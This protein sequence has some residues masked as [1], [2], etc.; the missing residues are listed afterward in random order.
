MGLTYPSGDARSNTTPG[1]PATRPCLDKSPA[2][3]ENPG[4]LPRKGPDRD[5]V[6]ARYR[7]MLRVLL[8]LL[9]TSLLTACGV[10]FGLSSEEEANLARYQRNAATYYGGGEFGRALDQARRG[11]EIDPEDYKLHLIKAWCALRQSQFDERRLEE[12]TKAFD[13]VLSL[14]SSGDQDPQAR[15]GYGA[16]HGKL[17]F[18][19]RRQ[20]DRLRTEAERLQLEGADLEERLAQATELDKESVRHFDLAEIELERLLD[21]GDLQLEAHYHLMYVSVWRDRHEEAVAHGSRYVERVGTLQAGIR[22]K[23]EETMLVDYERD[24]RIRLQKRLDQEVE[25]RAFLANLHF[26]DGHYELVVEQLDAVLLENP[27]RFNEF[28]NRARALHLLGRNEEAKRDFERFLI[29]T[30]LP[31]ENPQVKSA[32]AALK[33][34]E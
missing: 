2:L 21:S 12:A 23:L 22:G 33:D 1:E 16:A 34:I 9:L 30:N 18:E 4:S 6:A 26:K 19:L 32:L 8:L 20:A 7:P 15:L 25:V 3:G 14:R 5:R 27:G 29:S 11:L 28:F 17:A 31:R 13:Y 24:L 10:F